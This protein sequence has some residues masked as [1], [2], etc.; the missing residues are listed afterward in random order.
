M[1]NG[2]VTLTVL[3]S[4]WGFVYSAF[5]PDLL[6]SLGM[7]SDGHGGLWHAMAGG[8]MALFGMCWMFCMIR[9]WWM[10]LALLLFILD[11][12][13]LGVVVGFECDPDPGKAILIS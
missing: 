13:A 9:P 1:P 8:I 4:S 6:G 5:A 2:K 10:V 7:A 12:V 11:T 3:G